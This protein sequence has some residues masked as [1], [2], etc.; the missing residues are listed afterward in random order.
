MLLYFY[1]QCVFMLEMIHNCV[2]SYLFEFICGLVLDRLVFSSL[3]GNKCIHLLNRFA[4]FH[5][6]GFPQKKKKSHTRSFLRSSK[7]VLPS[8][9]SSR[10]SYWSLSFFLYRHKKSL[11]VTF[12][13]RP[14]FRTKEK[15]LFESFATIR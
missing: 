2:I 4:F 13:S 11:C 14:I 5:K 12:F 9:K 15:H 6:V 3:K 8:A 10:I 1:L 7:V